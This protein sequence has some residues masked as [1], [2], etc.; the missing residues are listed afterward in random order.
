M[1]ISN[2]QQRLLELIEQTDCFNEKRLRVVFYALY[3][4]EMKMMKDGETLTEKGVL[5]PSITVRC[6]L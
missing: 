3:L 4:V 5:R 1:L 6:G 2:I